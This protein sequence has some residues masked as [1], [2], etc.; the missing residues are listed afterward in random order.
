MT[1]WLGVATLA[2]LCV[3]VP[4]CLA[5]TIVI[6][7]T[8]NLVVIASDSKAQYQGAQGLP[9][10]C[11]IAKQ[12]E[13]YFVVAGIVQDTHRGFF[14]NRIVSSAIA[15]GSTLDEQAN[16]V[17]ND[18]LEAL[19]REL[20]G[21]R[22]E[23]PEE[24]KFAVTGESP[25]TIGLVAV[26]SG[27]PKVMVLSFIYDH[28]SGKMSVKRDSC[29]GTCGSEYSITQMGHV[30]PPEEFAK[31]TGSPTQVATK[32]VQLEIDRDPHEVGPPIEVLEIRPD[33]SQ[34]LQDDL[35]CSAQVSVRKKYPH[36][37]T[38]TF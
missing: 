16:A 8:S 21:L 34:W 5:T 36:N 19:T 12:N 18:M 3:T 27:I 35:N 2:A 4:S 14:A 24:F 38:V 20:S 32:L 31:A 26:E 22:T 6:V 33:E 9:E 15:R 11:K 10:V 30:L 37:V 23:N 17:E 25:S 13:T 7:R 29:P 1:R 28:A